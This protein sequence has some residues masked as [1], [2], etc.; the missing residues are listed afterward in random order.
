[1]ER[2]RLEADALHKEKKRRFESSSRG[3]APQRS[4]AHVPPPP[5]S[6]YT[7]GAMTAPSRGGGT[8]T[9]NYHRLAQGAGTWRTATPTSTGG[10]PF[11]CYGCGQSS[12]KITECL[13]KNSTP[14]ALTQ[15]RQAATPAAPC[16]N[17]VG[18]SWSSQPH[19]RGGRPG[20]S[21]H[22]V[23]YVFGTGSSSFSFVQLWSY[24]FLHF[25]Q[26]C[27]RA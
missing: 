5:R 21:R 26:V 13:V 25:H 11:T 22:G 1:M 20:R 23:Q 4:R 15:A 17:V 3:L 7:Q 8:Y 16:K 10:A 18:G 19:D 6:C 9:A 14:P 12:H 2:D 27:T 24:L